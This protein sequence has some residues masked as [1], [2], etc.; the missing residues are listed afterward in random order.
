MKGSTLLQIITLV[1]CTALLY[2]NYK[3]EKDIE[4]LQ[5]ENQALWERLDSLPR[6]QAAA[7]VTEQES[8]KGPIASFFNEIFSDL[9]EGYQEL[10]SE[11]K[12]PIIVL[13][14]SYRI[15]DRYVSHEI[16]EPDIMPSEPGVVAVGISV[17]YF[18]HVKKT[19]ILPS[20]TLNDEELLDACRKAAL[21]TI[22]NSDLGRFDKTLQKGTI[23]YTFKTK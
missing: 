14:T 19:S 16:H 8:G 22:F 17:D 1:I 21:Q 15:E 9:H 3:N 23:T 7:P 12:K 10:K 2:C 5:M 4:K 11:T 20:S 18:G 13:E 6:T